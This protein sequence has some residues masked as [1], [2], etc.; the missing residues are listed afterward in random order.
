VGVVV[1]AIIG[2]ILLLAVTIVICVVLFALGFLA[3]LRGWRAQRDVDD[4]LVKGE[5]KADDKSPDAL[6]D[7]VRKPFQ[8]SRVAAGKSAEAGRRSRFKL[9]F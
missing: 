1:L 2:W 8:T 7:W 6:T 5:D 4:A 3:P 9:P